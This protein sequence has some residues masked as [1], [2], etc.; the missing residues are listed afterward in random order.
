L[1]IWISGKL[2]NLDVFRSGFLPKSG[3]LGFA[4]ESNVKA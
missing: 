3:K 1:D 4:A 2:G